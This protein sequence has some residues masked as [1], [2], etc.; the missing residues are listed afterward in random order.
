MFLAYLI[1]NWRL[2][3]WGFPRDL[4]PDPPH[5]K[6]VITHSTPRLRRC[7]ASISIPIYRPTSDD[8]VGLG[9]IFFMLYVNFSQ[10]LLGKEGLMRKMGIVMIWHVRVILWGLLMYSL[11]TFYPT[12]FLSLICSHKLITQLRIGIKL[13]TWKL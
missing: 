7:P 8:V 6:P 13:W 12:R 11:C 1:W 2:Q 5:T 3:E 4:N 10:F 9:T